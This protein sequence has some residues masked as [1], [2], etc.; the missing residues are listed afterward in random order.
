LETIIR[1]YYN[2]EREALELI[3]DGPD[4]DQELKLLAERAARMLARR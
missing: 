1:R 2:T 4:V 3:L